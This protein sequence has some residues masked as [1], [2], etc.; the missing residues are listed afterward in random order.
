MP[1]HCTC[2]PHSDVLLVSVNILGPTHHRSGSLRSMLT[3]RL[4]QD[5]D[6]TYLGDFKEMRVNCLLNSSHPGLLAE[7]VCAQQAEVI[8]RVA[9]VQREDQVNQR[10]PAA[11][12]TP[13]LAY[14]PSCCYH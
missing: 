3:V 7:V 6:A 2:H 4:Q 14:D 9:V 12:T 11:H 5:Q 8:V 13:A 10:L 1:I